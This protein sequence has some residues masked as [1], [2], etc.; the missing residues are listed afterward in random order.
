MAVKKTAYGSL[1]S[2]GAM[3][4]GGLMAAPGA[5]MATNVLPQPAA[6]VPVN[7][8]PVP[9]AP[10]PQ[11]FGGQ[12]PAPTPYGNF[13]GLDPT[14]FQHSPDY[15]YLLDSQLKQSQRGAAKLG[16]LLTGGFQKSLQ[17]DAAGIAA[18]DYQN[19]Y[20]RALT[21]YTTNRDTNAQNYGQSMGQFQGNLGAFNANTNAALGYGR[22]G[23]DQQQQAYGQ[24]NQAAQQQQG[25]QQSL[26]NVAATNQNTAADAYEAQIE[27]QRR[28]NAQQAA[29]QPPPAAPR[30]PVAWR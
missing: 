22:L 1:A 8:P 4:N 20:N 26:N 25:Y 14:N 21:G 6:P 17:R 16:T 15:Q 18:G 3:T 10:T 13:A 23:L 28:F 9:G 7:A 2:P 5:A 19:A 12:A 11:T 24:A 27:A 29:A 30:R